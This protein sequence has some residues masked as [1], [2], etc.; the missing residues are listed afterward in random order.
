M[1]SEASETLWHE[2]FDLPS[3]ISGFPMQIVSTHG[4]KYIV[5]VE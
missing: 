5:L 3:G 2:S 4:L 1:F